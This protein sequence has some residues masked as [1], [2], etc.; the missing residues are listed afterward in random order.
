MTEEQELIVVTRD[1]FTYSRLR[2]LA[3]DVMKRLLEISQA[4]FDEYDMMCNFLARG[5]TCMGNMLLLKKSGEGDDDG[6]LGR[7]LMELLATA[8]YVIAEKKRVSAFRK[9]S[10]IQF[11]KAQNKFM[12]ARQESPGYSKEAFDQSKRVLRIV[13]Q[14][15]ARSQTSKRDK[16]WQLPKKEI[17]FTSPELSKLIGGELDKGWYERLYCYPAMLYVHI[18]AYTGAKDRELLLRGHSSPG[19]ADSGS[20]YMVGYYLLVVLALSVIGEGDSTFQGFASV[21]KTLRG[22]LFSEEG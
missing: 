13:R 3:V 12:Q 7:H 16:N 17:L 11:E 1:E 19:K 21:L 10:H 15:I 22:R 14:R 4:E 2:P 5:T 18:T 20:H 9:Y 8:C 6:M